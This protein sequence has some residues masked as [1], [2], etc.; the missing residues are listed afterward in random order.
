MPPL[1]G[2]SIPIGATLSPSGGTART[3]ADLGGDRVGRKL[4]VEDGAE[5]KDR[6]I[7]DVSTTEALPN[8]GVAGGMTPLKRRMSV[9][10][11]ITLSDGSTFLRQLNI[12][13]IEHVEVDAADITEM[14]NTGAILCTDADFLGFRTLGSKA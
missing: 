3:L 8:K 5:F 1:V 14:Y 12:E 11:P 4:L 7:I 9:K 6:T 2:G 13:S 10:V